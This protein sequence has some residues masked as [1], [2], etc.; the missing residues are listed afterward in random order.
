MSMV[1][2]Y[3]CDICRGSWNSTADA[4]GKLFGV[5]FKND[6]DFTL[7]H[8]SKTDG[9]HICVRCAIQL[10]KELN[11]ESVIHSIQK[12]LQVGEVK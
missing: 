4:Y 10:Q 11:T 3:R 1:K 7:E 9:V 2:T 12:A 5:F 6:T 8:L